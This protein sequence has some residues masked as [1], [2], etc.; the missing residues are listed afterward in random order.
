[1]L[2]LAD[3][4]ETFRDNALKNYGLDPV[5]YYTLPSYS[6]DAMLKSTKI[7][8]ELVQDPDMYQFF[9]DGKRGGIS[10]ISKRKAT[11]NNPEAVAEDGSISYDPSKPKKWLIYKWMQTTCME[12]Q[13]LG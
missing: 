13:C 2:Q 8:L 3:F 5:H 1:M 6:W 11:A 7:E 10:M 9:E 12:V 4:F